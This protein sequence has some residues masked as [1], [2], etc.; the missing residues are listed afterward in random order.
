M[1]PGQDVLDTEKGK[2]DPNAD[3]HINHSLSKHT[4]ILNCC[5]L[6]KA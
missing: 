5:Q 2:S 1:V 3:E 6:R 4:Q